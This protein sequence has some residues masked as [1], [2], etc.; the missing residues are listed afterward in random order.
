MFKVVMSSSL[1]MADY[2]PYGLTVSP[3]QWAD[4]ALAALVQHMREIIAVENIGVAEQR[5]HGADVVAA[6]LQMRGIG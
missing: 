3:V 4:H 2:S 6:F 1:K 5:L